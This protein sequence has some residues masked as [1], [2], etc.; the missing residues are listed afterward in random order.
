MLLSY[1]TSW[2]IKTFH[3]IFHYNSCISWWI[4]T[5]ETGINT[6]GNRYKIYNFSLTVCSVVIMLSAVR[7]HCGRRLPA[8]PLIARMV[9]ATFAES[10]PMFVFSQFSL[11]YAL[12]SLRAEN[13]LDS[14]TFWSKFYLQNS[15]QWNGIWEYDECINCREFFPLSISTKSVKIYQEMLELSHV[16]RIAKYSK[17]AHCIIYNIINKS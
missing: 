15:M 13:I 8:V 2:A 3:F 1:C 10:R 7:D 16:T 6:V 5:L 11:G 12:L 17:M 9:V 4:F 14:R